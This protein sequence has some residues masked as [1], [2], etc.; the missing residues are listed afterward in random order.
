MAKALK[1]KQTTFGEISF[2][3]S[4]FPKGFMSLIHK[5]ILVCNC[6][7]LQTKGNMKK[8]ANA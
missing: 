7:K 2:R 4:K 8:Q 1:R 3:E 5:E 6:C